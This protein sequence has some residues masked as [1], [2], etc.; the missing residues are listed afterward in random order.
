PLFLFYI[1]LMGMGLLA[2]TSANGSPTA[3]LIIAIGIAV[4]SLVGI[5]G[6]VVWMLYIFCRYAFAVT[7][8]TLEK[9]SAKNSLARSRFLTDNAKWS[10]LGLAFLTVLMSVIL[11]YVLELPALLAGGAVIPKAGNHLTVANT[12]WVYFAQFLSGAIT[13]PITT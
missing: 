10:V 5:M 11:S 3:V 13:G 4:I 7:A 9:L 6:S 1:L 2:T 12:A 8:C